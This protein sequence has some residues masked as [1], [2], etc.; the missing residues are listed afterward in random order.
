MITL[1]IHVTNKYGLDVRFDDTKDIIKGQPYRVTSLDLP[2]HVNKV[3]LEIINCSKRDI[4][5]VI[6]SN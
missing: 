5:F 1:R 3:E 2:N 4:S 6:L